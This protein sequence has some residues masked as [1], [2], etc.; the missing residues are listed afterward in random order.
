MGWLKLGYQRPTRTNYEQFLRR[1]ETVAASQVAS[2]KGVEYPL[3]SKNTQNE[4]LPFIPADGEL[5]RRKG[6]LKTMYVC[7]E[8]VR[9]IDRC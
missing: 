9:D 5:E 2:V 3:C 1:D 4:D 8:R 6:R 7:R